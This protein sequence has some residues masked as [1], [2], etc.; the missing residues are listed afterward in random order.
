MIGSWLRDGGPSFHWRTS[1][2]FHKAETLEY[3]KQDRLQNGNVEQA[4]SDAAGAF[5]P[6]RG[7]GS[8]HGMS[9][10]GSEGFIRTK[11]GN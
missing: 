8:S 4:V 5:L 6:G 3:Y 1:D 9:I 2:V 11:G 7:A 10:G